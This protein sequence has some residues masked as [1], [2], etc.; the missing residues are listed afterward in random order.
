MASCSTI[1]NAI[2]HKGQYCYKPNLQA[3]CCPQYTIKFCDIHLLPWI[4]V[5]SRPK[6]RCDCIQALQ[7]PETDSE[8]VGYLLNMVSFLHSNCFILFRWNRFILHDGQNDAMELDNEKYFTSGTRSVSLS[9]YFF[10]SRAQV[11][12]VKSKAT[13]ETEESCSHYLVECGHP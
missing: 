10:K 2:F 13:S 8:S 1:L 5:D 6:I 9:N 11:S 4:I 12:C 7:K 3:S